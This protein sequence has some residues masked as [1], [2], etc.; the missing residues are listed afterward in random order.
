[1][2]KSPVLYGGVP[3][4]RDHSWEQNTRTLLKFLAQRR[5][6]NELNA[7]T[8]ARSA[9]LLRHGLA[10]LEERGYVRSTILDE[11]IYWM[12]VRGLWS[13]SPQGKKSSEEG[14]DDR[15]LD[16]MIPKPPH[17]PSIPG[18]VA[19]DQPTLDTLPP[20]TEPDP[21]LPSS[22]PQHSDTI[23]ASHSVDEAERQVDDD[24]PIS[25]IPSPHD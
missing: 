6:W 11:Q 9:S 2:A 20:D 8:G 15:Y 16:P 12:A 23:P 13:D 21:R 10:W 18:F 4:M 1:M 7:W 19:G 5:S 14:G 17:L 22:P 25:T 3:P 24:T